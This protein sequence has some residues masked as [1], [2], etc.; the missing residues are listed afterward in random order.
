MRTNRVTVAFV[1]DADGRLK[2]ILT[3]EQANQG[4]KGSATGISLCFPGYPCGA[5]P[6]LGSRGE[7]A[8]SCAGWKTTPTGVITRPELIQVMYSGSGY[9][10]EN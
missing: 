1:F 2:G 7:R 8:G 6:T 9:T 10:G 4:R 5:D 3:M